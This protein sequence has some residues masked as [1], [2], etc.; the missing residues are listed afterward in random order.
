MDYFVQQ[1]WL[2]TAN[3]MMKGQVQKCLRS[4]IRKYV[5][6]QILRYSEDSVEVS[7]EIFPQ[8]G[9]VGK[10]NVCHM[11]TKK[12]RIRLHSLLN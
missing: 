9:I 8:N 6:E 7:E 2:R 4:L 5:L 3:R 1:A 11:R 12:I 10:G